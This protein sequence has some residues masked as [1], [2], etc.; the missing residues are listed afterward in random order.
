M[1]TRDAC[2]ARDASDPLAPLRR[3]F[4][5]DEVD[6]RRLVYLDGNSLGV[7]PKATAGRVRDV[8]EREWGTGLIR[9]WNA[10]GWITL[11]QRF[12]NKIARLVGAGSDELIVAD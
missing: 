11:S 7:L 4:D 3:Q 2:A 1:I 6:A 10:A 5:L 9:S 8:V 12:G